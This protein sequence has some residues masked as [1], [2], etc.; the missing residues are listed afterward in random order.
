MW[1]NHNKRSTD[2]HLVS[3]VEDYLVEV[4]VD[5]GQLVGHLLVLEGVALVVE[6]VGHGLVQKQPLLGVGQGVG[7]LA[8]QVP[9]Q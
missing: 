8:S 9:V 7:A 1:T 5:L 2:D 4:L 6:D 3:E